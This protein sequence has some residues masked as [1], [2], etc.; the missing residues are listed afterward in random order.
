MFIQQM[1]KRYLIVQ[2]ITF[3]HSYTCKKIS[4]L[5]EANNCIG[6]VSI[7]VGYILLINHNCN[8]I[9][10]YSDKKIPCRV[11]KYIFCSIQNHSKFSRHCKISNICLKMNYSE[12]ILWSK[13]PT[14]D[15]RNIIDTALESL[16]FVLYRSNVV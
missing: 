1:Q 11:S 15:R 5:T 3:Q 7:D 10:G 16:K 13:K 8:I 6:V 14:K 4:V 9:A 12:N 2:A